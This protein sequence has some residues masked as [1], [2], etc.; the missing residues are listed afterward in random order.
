M[1]IPGQRPWHTRMVG[2]WLFALSILL[3][4]TSLPSTI[5]AADP[6]TDARDALRQM[7]LANAYLEMDDANRACDTFD[8]VLVTFPTW[9]I[10]LS[11]RIRCGIAKGDTVDSLSGYLD[12]A[13]QFGAPFHV[14]QRLKGLLKKHANRPPPEPKPVVIETQE[15]KPTAAPIKEPIRPKPDPRLLLRSWSEGDLRTVLAQVATYEGTPDLSA[16]V[17]RYG[18]EAAFLLRDSKALDR[19]MPKL[20][21]KTKSAVLLSRYLVDLKQRGQESEY[22]R[23]LKVW[24]V[25]S[26]R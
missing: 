16:S 7:R 23:W 4:F 12:T 17:L 14:V 20:L 3:A 22:K 15:E 11:G 9:W 19:Y 21:E 5:R 8:Q 10:A 26:Q 6:P 2:S 1:I 18:V 24:K 13:T 25:W